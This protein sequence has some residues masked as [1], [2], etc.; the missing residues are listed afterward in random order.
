MNSTYDKD[1][2]YREHGGLFC[3]SIPHDWVTFEF[4]TSDSNNAI[5]W[6]HASIERLTCKKIHHS[7]D[8]TSVQIPGMIAKNKL[9]ERAWLACEP[10]DVIGVL[11]ELGFVISLKFEVKPSAILTVARQNN[12]DVRLYEWT[13]ETIAHFRNEDD[14]A[15]MRIAV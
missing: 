8:I 3:I 10:W 15:F 6:V 4:E 12:I 13:G 1:I 14:A 7:V 11:E 2:C 5:G 9:C